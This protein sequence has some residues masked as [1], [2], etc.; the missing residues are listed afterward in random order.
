MTPLRGLALVLVGLALV[1]ALVGGEYSLFNLRELRQQ[2]RAETATLTELRVVVDS[3]ER[4][5][6]AIETDPE[7]LER[8][9]RER[10]GMLR[11]GEFGYRIEREGPGSRPP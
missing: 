3:L 6:R 5:L 7:V 1:F 8:I 10:Y 2:E 4:E 11:P 9:A